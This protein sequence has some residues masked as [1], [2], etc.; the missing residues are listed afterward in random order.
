VAGSFLGRRIAWLTTAVLFVA[1]ASAP[2]PEEPTTTSKRKKKRK[3]KKKETQ[4][5]R[6]DNP[7]KKSSDAVTITDD[8]EVEEE[9]APKKK[10]SDDDEG[11]EVA[12]KAKKK[13]KSDDEA[14]AKAKRKEQ[15]QAK[16]EEAKR[17][18]EEAAEAEAQRKEE[19]EAERA[20]A[21]AKRKEEEEAERAAA[22]AKRKKEIEAEE[23]AFKREQEEEAEEEEVDEKPAKKKV[24]AKAKDEPAE[25]DMTGGI[26]ENAIEME[27][28]EEPPMGERRVAAIPV[29][30]V[31]SDEEAPI[32]SDEPLAP[33]ATPRAINDRPLTLGKG[34]LSV[35]GGLRVSVLTL[36]N[37]AGMNVSTTSQGFALGGTYGVS[38]KLEVGG[39][40]TVGISPG[41]IKGPLTLHGAYRA[42]AS[43]KLDVA[44]AGGLAV[45]YYDTTDPMTMT[46]TSRAL[47]SIN[48]GAWA[49]YRIG[50]K[51][52]LFTGLPALPDSTVSQSKLSIPL[53]PLAYQL[54][55][56]LNGGGAIA[57]DVPVG[58]GYQAS[59]KLYAFVDIDLAHIRIKNT[60]N[61]FLFKDFIP[62]QL[63]A[64]YTLNKLDL[65]ASLSDDFKQGFDYLRFDI[66]ARYSL[67]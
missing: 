27:A 24:A 3:K 41:S 29:P 25:V 63:G 16:A 48:V 39:D 18:K 28:E 42:S 64:F 65:G 40:Y 53:P 14:D 62:I 31:D 23:A 61:R 13:K 35:H 47:A 52:S 43:A 58:L 37:T 36:P 55:V 22:K 67:K 1:C 66:V 15:E 46:T 51:A 11:D 6:P 45:D 19:E 56:G 57:L 7:F 44:I 26:D 33:G 21:K 5:E 50:R 49:R 30:G 54:T 17:K 34:K 59:P 20:A 32:E 60:V 4:A 10:S 12:T 38:D 9:E 2:E 8:P